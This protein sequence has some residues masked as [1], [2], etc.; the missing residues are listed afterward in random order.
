MRLDPARSSACIFCRCRRDKAR[1]G[2]DS[3]PHLVAVVVQ[4]ITQSVFE[5]LEPW[6]EIRPLIEAVAENGLANLFR[7]RGAHA[8]LGLVKLDASRFELKPAEI[9]DAPHA[10]FKIL[11]DVL[12]LNAKNAARQNPIPMPHQLKISPVVAR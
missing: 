12:M 7:A 2:R 8:A 1:F 4:C 11:D 10:A 6:L 5:R 9:Q 3:C